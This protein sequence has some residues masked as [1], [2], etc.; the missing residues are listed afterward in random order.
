MIISFIMS[1]I[2]SLL[3][4][5]WY[6]PL[7][8]RIVYITAVRSGSRGVKVICLPTTVRLSVRMHARR[9]RI[10]SRTPPQKVAPPAPHTLHPITTNNTYKA[11]RTPPATLAQEGKIVLSG[12]REGPCLIVR[13]HA[14]WRL[15]N[16]KS[17][18]VMFQ[19]N[20]PQTPHA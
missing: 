19:E 2:L 18:A 9:T 13:L 11:L 5:A 16:A 3:T 8:I 7:M 10:S 15:E 1:Y 17:P 4:P 14:N 6:Y 20:N 12:Q